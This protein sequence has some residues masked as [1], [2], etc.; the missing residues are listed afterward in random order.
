MSAGEGARGYISIGR[1]SMW[2]CR[3]CVSAV[4]NHFHL[5][6]ELYYSL[7]FWPLPKFATA[8]WVL[9]WGRP[10]LIRSAATERQFGHSPGEA[11][12]LILL[13]HMNAACMSQPDVQGEYQDGKT[14][15]RDLIL[16]ASPTV[17]LIPTVPWP[18]NGLHKANAL[19]SPSTR[20]F[21]PGEPLVRY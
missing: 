14:C 1:Y 12:S 6:V 17:P 2:S 4:Q 5:Y 11:W 18:P 15:M 21:T 10:L 9:G 7:L 13:H 16:H 3:N 20:Q 8:R 19:R